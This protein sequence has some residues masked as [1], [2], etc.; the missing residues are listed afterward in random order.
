MDVSEKMYA[1]ER[2]H[3]GEVMDDS[4]QILSHKY[5]Y[6]LLFVFRICH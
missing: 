5:F 6:D 1:G 4:L 2:M 3:A